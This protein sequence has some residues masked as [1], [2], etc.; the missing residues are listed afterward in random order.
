M[1]QV[2]IELS[3][4]TFAAMGLAG[5]ERPAPPGGSRK[6]T[7]ETDER[8][9]LRL[10][11]FQV[12]LDRLVIRFVQLCQEDVLKTGPHAALRVGPHAKAHHRLDLEDTYQRARLFRIAHAVVEQVPSEAVASRVGMAGEQLCQCWKASVAS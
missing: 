1:L 8:T 5:K 11:R 10:D 9:G 2:G 3:A 6:M 7:V 4:V 12:C